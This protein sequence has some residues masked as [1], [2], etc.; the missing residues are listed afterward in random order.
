MTSV[1]R[2]AG[3][4]LNRERKGLLN[5]VQYSDK[6]RANGRFVGGSLVSVSRAVVPRLG[7]DLASRSR[8]GKS[9]VSFWL[10]IRCLVDCVSRTKERGAANEGCRD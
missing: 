10:L 1:R 3:L 5:N 8:D 2:V 9:N 7:S 4:V 6:G